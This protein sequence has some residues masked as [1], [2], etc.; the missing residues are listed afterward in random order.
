MLILQ[1]YR[2]AFP[3]TVQ[4]AQSWLYQNYI[5]N[6]DSNV[7]FLVV[8]Q[9]NKSFRRHLGDCL[10]FSRVFFIRNCVD[11]N[12][13]FLLTCYLIKH[14]NL[15]IL[16]SI[17]KAITLDPS[18]RVQKALS[19]FCESSKIASIHDDYLGLRVFSLFQILCKIIVLFPSFC[20]GK[21]F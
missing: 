14:L 2:D 9:L 4:L 19:F 17:T 20:F 10:V 18:D 12:L 6:K 21:E 7:L 15:Y 1:F 11:I 3:S 8:V 16:I 5:V 13:F